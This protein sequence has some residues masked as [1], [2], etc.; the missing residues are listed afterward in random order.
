MLCKSHSVIEI[1]PLF[2]YR[3]LI[4][5]NRRSG[6][7]SIIYC[8]NLKTSYSWLLKLQ[9]FQSSDWGLNVLLPSGL[10][11]FC[12][13]WEI[14][15]RIA[16]IILRDKHSLS[17]VQFSIQTWLFCLICE[18]Q[19]VLLSPSGSIQSEPTFTELNRTSYITEVVHLQTNNLCISSEALL[20]MQEPHPWGSGGSWS[21]RTRGSPCSAS[22]GH[23]ANRTG[24]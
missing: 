1:C 8:K 20:L 5:A 9:T 19:G 23:R 21:L 24:R 6:T 4:K 13:R 22:R 12:C 18:S 3:T 2:I 10:L 16:H 17:P 11:L 14:A 7:R 15:H